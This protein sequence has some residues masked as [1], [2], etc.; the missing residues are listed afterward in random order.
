LPAAI[1]ELYGLRIETAR[2]ASELCTGFRCF[3]V[4][5]LHVMSPVIFKPR[6]SSAIFWMGLMLAAAPETAVAAPASKLNFSR[7][8]QPVLEKL[9]FDCHGDGVTKGGLALDAFKSDKK[10]L[11]DTTTWLAVWRK[12]DAQ[13]MPPP[14]VPQPTEEERRLVQDWIVRRVFAL[15]PAKPD[16]GRV[17]LRRL[18]RAQYENT[19]RDWLGVDFAADE[20]FPPDDTGYGF[21]N[22]GDV[23]TLSPLLMEKYLSAATTITDDFL[24]K[25]RP[26]IPVQTLGGDGFRE[27]GAKPRSDRQLAFARPARTTLERT[28][29]HS[30]RYR[31]AVNFRVTGSENATTET[32]RLM[33]WANTNQLQEQFIGWDNRQSITIVAEAEFERGPLLLGL[34]LAPANPPLAGENNLSL[35][36]NHVRLEGPLDGGQ[37]EYPPAARRFFPDGAPPSDAVQREAYAAKILRPLADRG[38][39]RPVDEETLRRLVELAVAADRKPGIGFEQAIGQALTAILS[40]PRFL[41]QTEFPPA[42]ASKSR[43]LPVD[44][45][46]LASRLSYFLWNSMPDDELF[47]LARTNGLRSQLTAQTDRLLAD[48]R[49]ARF[50][51]SFV[52]QWLQTRD[53]D[54][55][56]PDPKRILALKSYDEP[57][58]FFGDDL[59]RAMRQ[60]TE[61]L[62]LDLLQH[63]GTLTDLLTTRDTYLN[64]P[65]ARLY[66]VP[67]VIGAEMRKVS[68]PA[69][70]PRAGI[71]THGSFLLVTSN[72][73]RTSPV[74]RGLFILDNL[75]GTPPPPPPPNVPELE[76]AKQSAVKD[77]TMRDLMVLHREKPLCASCHERMDPP[78]LAFEQFNALGA[79]RERENGRLIETSGVLITGESFQ[80]PQDL[81]RVFTGP[82]RHDL[83]RCVAEKLLTYALGRGIDYYDIPTIT[84]LVSQLE[85]DQGRLR[86]LIHA[87]VQSAPFLMRRNEPTQMIPAS[88]PLRHR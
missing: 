67:G 68:L 31:V 50:V 22:I 5:D 32:A 25:V 10:F 48:P 16:P 65:L 2:I 35:C 27:T 54:S 52:G 36:V 21:D 28:L 15:D 39:R 55:V 1:H 47:A 4:F 75:L 71:L 29:A 43:V 69:D 11:Q 83:F 57:G 61:L 64:E 56:V 74:K 70:G 3:V 18:N 9:C 85:K 86:T 14:R 41:F 59:R 38:F 81:A 8:I 24:A 76:A 34:Q 19:L 37:L 63:D 45:F 30:G 60:E 51:E 87:A 72:P 49:A 40:S 26:H 44:D 13:L 84:A 62:F 58:A 6:F 80:S 42:T 23:L 66:Q 82:R 88:Q 17:T 77:A 79:F 33:L 46:A 78:G 20:Q 53:M 7:Q 12:L 73:T